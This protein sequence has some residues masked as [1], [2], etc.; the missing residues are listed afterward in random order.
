MAPKPLDQLTLDERIEERRDRSQLEWIRAHEHQVVQDPVPLG[1]HGPDPL[2]A[3]GD[4][5]PREPFDSDD[6]AELVVERREPVVAVH[7]DEHLSRVAV[8]GELLR[9]PV[10][11]ADHRLR[12]G[13]D[14]AVELEYEPEYAVGRRMLRP[15]IDDHLLGT[16]G[17]R[18]NDLDIEP[19]APNHP[20]L[21][22][23]GE[24]VAF[25]GVHRFHPSTDGRERP[26]G[27]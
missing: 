12:P 1:E 5:D 8:L 17:P 27:R 20:V 11:V 18:G 24:D 4:L 13:D 6:P 16:E 2:G 22:G 26:T 21:G 25:L 15:D 9:A 19:P 23:G 3:L 7:Q 14:L 10:H